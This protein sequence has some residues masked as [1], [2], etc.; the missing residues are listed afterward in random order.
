MS[1][2][3]ERVKAEAESDSFGVIMFA[4][5]NVVGDFWVKLPSHLAMIFDILLLDAFLTNVS[6]SLVSF[7]ITHF[8]KVLFPLAVVFLF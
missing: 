3:L 7:N 5:I 1:E 2:S 4:V 8:W 6:H